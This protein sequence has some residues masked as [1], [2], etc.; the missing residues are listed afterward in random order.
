MQGLLNLF[1]RL[2]CLFIYVLIFERL[3]YTAAFYTHQ[4]QMQK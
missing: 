1:I 3:F 4:L 2:F